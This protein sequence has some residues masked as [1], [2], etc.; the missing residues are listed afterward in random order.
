MKEIRMH[1]SDQLHSCVKA[2]AAALGI[3]ISVYAIGAVNQRLS[4]D[5]KKMI[6]P[7]QAER[8]ENSTVENSTENKEET[9]EDKENETK[10]KKQKKGELKETGESKEEISPS[11][12]TAR[13]RG[14]LPF[15]DPL[16]EGAAEM[17]RPTEAQCIA[18]GATAGIPEDAVRNWL[19]HMRKFDWHFHSG[20]R[21]TVANFR[22]SLMSWWR[23]EKN[24]DTGG[25]SACSPVKR[26]GG[27]AGARPSRDGE[28][29]K[30]SWMPWEQWQFEESERMNNL[31]RIEKVERV[32]AALEK[33]RKEF[34]IC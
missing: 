23:K 1:I 27:R 12:P 26:D 29:K 11:T 18:A 15:P 13:A 25:A 21:V 8:V 16:V 24:G 34:G 33:V 31:R 28:R 6:S 10:E 9:K 20:G 30:P 3:S 19:E 7:I 22:T 14:E 5:I 17:Q 2:R 32:D 4:M